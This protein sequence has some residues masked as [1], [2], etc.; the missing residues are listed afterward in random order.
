MPA[1]IEI[2]GLTKRYGVGD[3]AVAALKGVDMTVQ[4][5]ERGRRADWAQ[6]LGQ[7][8]AASAWVR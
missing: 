6:R 3:A 1:A 2:S 4:P 7:E 5:G 8:H